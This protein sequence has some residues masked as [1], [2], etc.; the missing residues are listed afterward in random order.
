MERKYTYISTNHIGLY[1]KYGYTFLETAQN[2]SG[3][4]TR[5]YRK[6]LLDGRAG[7]GAPSKKTEPG[8][9]RRLS[10]QRV[11]APTRRRIAGFRATIAF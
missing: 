10:A 2:I 5:I 6:A 1:E 8:I 3:G 4:E 11:Q 7:N 9:N